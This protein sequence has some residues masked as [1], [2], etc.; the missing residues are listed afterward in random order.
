MKDNKWYKY[1]CIITDQ[2]HDNIY[3][4]EYSLDGITAVKTR[5]ENTISKIIATKYDPTFINEVIDSEPE[6]DRVENMSLVKEKTKEAQRTPD[7]M[8]KYILLF[9]TFL[10]VL[11]V[12]LINYFK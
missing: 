11:V 6:A 12:F 2:W 9:L 4:S 1:L 7:I 5:N 8:I 3:E 10:V